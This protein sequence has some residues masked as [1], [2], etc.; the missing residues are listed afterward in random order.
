[1]YFRFFKFLQS[2][3]SYLCA[4]FIVFYRINGTA[5]L[6][7]QCDLELGIF[8]EAA[9]LAKERI[10]LVVVNGPTVTQCNFFKF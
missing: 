3:Q 2:K 4:V 7:V 1:M 10:P 8:A 9:I 6:C 5:W